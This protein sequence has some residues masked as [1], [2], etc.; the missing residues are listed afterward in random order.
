MNTTFQALDFQAK[1]QV[2]ATYKN[3]YPLANNGQ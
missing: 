1:D 3:N 2:K